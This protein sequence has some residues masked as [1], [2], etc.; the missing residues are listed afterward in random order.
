MQIDAD[1]TYKGLN[2]L[3]GHS[4]SSPSAKRSCLSLIPVRWHST[5]AQRLNAIHVIESLRVP[6]F[7][8]FDP[9]TSSEP[10]NSELLHAGQG[11]G[12]KALRLRIR[13]KVRILSD[14]EPLGSAF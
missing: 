3:F 14:F 7:A 2:D 9:S 12:L 4:L 6:A 10:A 11:L 5:G 1:S 13:F 8:P